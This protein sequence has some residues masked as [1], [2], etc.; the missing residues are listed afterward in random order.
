[1][2]GLTGEKIWIDDSRPAPKGYRWCKTYKSAIATINYFSVCEG[3]IDEICF[4]HDIRCTYSGYDIA[5]YLIENNISIGGYSVHSMNPVGRRNIIDLL[6]H[7]GY[8]Y[9]VPEYM[10]N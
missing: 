9:I 1:M 4:D 10:K 7:Y 3:G 6:S 2:N 8:K 5:K